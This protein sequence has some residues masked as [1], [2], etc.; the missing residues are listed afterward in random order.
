MAT[1]TMA[2]ITVIPNF[3][4]FLTFNVFFKSTMPCKCVIKATTYLHTTQLQF[5]VKQFDWDCKLSYNG[6]W[7]QGKYLLSINEVLVSE[8]PPAP[9]I[10]KDNIPLV[11]QS[12][13][14]VFL[15][16][17]TKRV[18]FQL[19]I[20]GLLHQF[21]AEH[22]CRSLTTFLEVDD[23]IMKQWDGVTLEK[24]SEQ[25]YTFYHLG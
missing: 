21:I 6:D 5:S 16:D 18:T 2:N 7:R 20:E 14:H 22:N 13:N 19:F 8:L 25:P 11:C 9:P 4:A 17:V 15:G 12:D 10:K 23:K 1:Q 24:L 3:F